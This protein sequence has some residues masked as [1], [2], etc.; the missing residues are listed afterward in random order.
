MARSTYSTN[1]SLTRTYLVV[2]YEGLM[3]LIWLM[4]DG[5]APPSHLLPRVARFAYVRSIPIVCMSVLMNRVRYAWGRLLTKNQNLKSRNY[6]RD[7]TR[8]RES[9]LVYRQSF[10][11]SHL[12]E[13]I[14]INN[15]APQL[16]T[17][18]P[19]SDSLMNQDYSRPGC[20][21]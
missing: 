3:W 11:F 13:Q 6:S 1:Y 4:A 17:H 9:S 18:P 16:C 20:H 7:S 15:I 12:Q 21:W 14:F 5:P 10:D 8:E 2:F 19:D